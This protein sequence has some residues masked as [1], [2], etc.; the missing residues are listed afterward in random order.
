MKRNMN[1][2]LSTSGILKFALICLLFF[3]PDLVLAQLSGIYTIG[4]DASDNYAT[5]AELMAAIEQPAPGINGDVVFQ[6]R[7]GTYQERVIMNFNNVT[8]SSSDLSISFIGQGAAPENTLII[9]QS[10]SSANNYTLQVNG[11]Q[12]ILFQN[13]KFQNTGLVHANVVGVG[14][15]TSVSGITF[16]NCNFQGATAYIDGTFPT[17]LYFESGTNGIAVTNTVHRGSNYGITC[18]SGTRDVSI[19]N[20]QLYEQHVQAMSL[21]ISNGAVDSNYIEKIADPANQYNYGMELWQANDFIVKSNEFVLNHA[22]I[23]ALALN[24]DFVSANN[25]NVVERNTFTLTNLN[26]GIRVSGSS[27]SLLRNNFGS[28]K[29]VKF[30]V[31]LS[32]AGDTYVVQNTFR[33]DSNG[34]I[35]VV[36]S[37][38]NIN[39]YNNVMINEGTGTVYASLT[40]FTS[41]YNLVYSSGEEFSSDDDTFELHQEKSEQDA[42][43]TSILP[44]FATETSPRIC[45]Y[46]VSNAGLDLTTITSDGSA[47]VS[48]DYFGTVRSIATPDIGAYEFDL[49][50]TTIFSQDTLFM[51]LGNT[52]VV[53]PENTFVSYLWLNDSTIISTKE[54]F[55]N[56]KFFIQVVDADKCTLLD[57]LAIETQTVSVDLGED[58]EICAGSSV[59]LEAE[60]GFANYTWSTGATTESLEVSEEGTYTVLVSNALG[61]TDFDEVV[62]TLSD[63][64]IAPNFLVSGIGCTSDTIQFIEVSDIEPDAVLWA[65]GDG[66]ISED[67]NPTHL[68]N[69]VGD[70]RV[71]MTA[72]LGDC[73]LDIEKEVVITST[74]P[75]FLVAYYPLDTAANDISDNEFDGTLAGDLA[76]VEDEDRGTVAYFD[77]VDDYIELTTSGALDLVSSNFTVSAWVKGTSFELTHPILATGAQVDNQGLNLGMTSGKAQLGFFNNNL[78]GTQTIATEEWHFITYVYDIDAQKM[79]IYV[80]GEKDA[81]ASGRQAFSGFDLVHIGWAQS[82]NFFSG[83]IDDLRIWKEALSSEEIFE[84]WSGYSTEL[85]AYYSLSEDGNDISGNEF[86]GTVNGSITFV[87]DNERGSVASFGGASRDYI[88]LGG[89]EELGIT[90]S[91]FVVSAWVKVD[92]FD[93]TDL[94]ILGSSETQG[95]RQGLHLLAR[96]QNPHFGFWGI[97]TSD[98]STT[99]A[100]DQW[101]HLSFI[102]DQNAKTQ[103]IYVNG[104][105]TAVGIGKESFIGTST[106]LIGNSIDYNKGFNGAIH[107]LKIRK[108]T[109]GTPD[110]RV[111]GEIEDEVMVRELSLFP[112][113]TEDYV[114]ISLTNQG[115]FNGTLSVFDIHGNLVE[116]IEVSGNQN[117]NTYLSL[118]GLHSGL[119]FI[120]VTTNQHQYVQ[121]LIIK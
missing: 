118:N 111:E 8:F 71:N 15:S 50:G 79:T 2:I 61:C 52:Q 95:I 90:E 14:L 31:F 26:D 75:D 17:S 45:H 80:D 16:N 51:C 101:A 28:F 32:D 29:D 114:N 106:L 103:T 69:A 93:K 92:A 21:S 121:R 38:D 56:D 1:Q 66:H 67:Q 18:W 100:A 62:V 105:I 84:N 72:V 48:F 13:M 5:F 76:F 108:I 27:N 83:Y 120:R 77:G 54:A 68:Y 94:T 25:Y 19:R 82:T 70:Y 20:N 24:D 46:S 116:Q 33:M 104:Q 97:D 49:P 113:P 7:A 57:S 39:S 74:C 110:G 109:S 87:Q 30:G 42:N 9:F 78:N 44:E 89:A 35:L 81:E 88:M 85:V 119:Y 86:N 12:N 40:D 10:T 23:A 43:S 60:T 64:F 4:S 102:Y 99:L 37:G 34:D 107:D 65:F 22:N 73:S 36:V 63:D 115:E 117:N 96:N 47:L 112:N 53:Q 98:P 41:D 6:V 58:Q 3:N 55:E 11:G 91:G 59:T